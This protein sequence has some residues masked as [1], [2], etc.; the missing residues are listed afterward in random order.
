MVKKLI[1]FEL[2]YTGLPRKKRDFRD[3]IFSIR[4]LKFMFPF[5]WF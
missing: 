4:V 1:I 3:E 2:Y 5:V